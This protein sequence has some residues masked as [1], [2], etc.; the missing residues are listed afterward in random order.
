MWI[1]TVFFCSFNH[2]VY[3]GARV[4]SAGSI[5]KVQFFRPIVNGLGERSARLL[6]FSNPFHQKEILQALA[7]DFC[8]KAIALPNVLLG[9]TLG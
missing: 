7:S 4:C 9:N 8:N 6:V 3:Y 1:Q 2:A 5:A